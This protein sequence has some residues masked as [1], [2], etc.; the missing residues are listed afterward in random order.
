MLASALAPGAAALLLDVAGANTLL[1]V[2]LALAVVNVGLALAIVPY[3][4]RSP[5]S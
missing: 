1:A 5:T 2:L 3:S 4:R